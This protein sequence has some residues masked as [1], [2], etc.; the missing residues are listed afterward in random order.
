MRIAIHQSNFMPWYPFFQKMAQC[1]VFVIL[2][3]CQYEKNGW[4]NRCM[5]NG[6]WWTK[7]ITKGT[8]PIVNKRYVDNQRLIDVNIPFI[9]GMARVLGIDTKK[10]VLD[11][12]TE[13]TG[14]ERL[15]DIIKHFNGDEYLTNLEAFGKYLDKEKVEKAGIKIVPFKTQYKKHVFEMFDLYGVDRTIR[16]L[17]D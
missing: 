4:Q 7:P 11:Y 3:H 2:V 15:I 17:N 13:L 14:T 5:V 6:K 12:P 10:I 8:A 9:Y 1:D 16:R